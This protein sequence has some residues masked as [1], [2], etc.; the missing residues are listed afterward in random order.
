MEFACHGSWLQFYLPP[1]YNLD[2][3]SPF[4]LPAL[5]A[6][7]LAKAS[8]KVKVFNLS[9]IMFCQKDFYVKECKYFYDI[10]L[11]LKAIPYI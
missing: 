2:C 1:F 4:T 3:S 8:E 5:F 7:N 11:R 6:L 9:F 10:C